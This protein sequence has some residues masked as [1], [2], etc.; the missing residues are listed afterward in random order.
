MTEADWRSCE[1][2]EGMVEWVRGRGLLTDRKARLFGAACCRRIQHLIPDERSLRAVEAAELAADGRIGQEEVMTVWR[3]AWEAANEV[4][5]AAWAVE[6]TPGGVPRW[7]TESAVVA[8]GHA[9][10]G[11]A[12]SAADAAVGALL[13]DPEPGGGEELWLLERRQQAALLR[14]L[15]G[16]QSFRPVPFDPAWRTP[17]VLALATTVYE[18]QSFCDL[19]ILADALEEAGAD[20]QEILWHLR[21]R[22]TGHIRGCWC[23]DL[24]LEKE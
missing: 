1:E 8:A 7:D 5:Q 18:E 24:I 20:Y 9:I 11:A 3:A 2:P 19:P 12:V 4:H 13:L 6:M 14:D 21:R 15:F 17:A 22:E 16:P 10:A 23:L